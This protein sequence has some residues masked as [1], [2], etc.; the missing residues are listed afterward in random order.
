[1]KL[2]AQA[3]AELQANTPSVSVIERVPL[4]QA[5]GRIAACDVMSELAIPPADNSAMDGFA[6]HASA[7]SENVILSISQRIPAG[8]A[9]MPLEAGTAARIFTGANIPSNADTVVIQENCKF[10]GSEVGGAV[11]IRNVPERG[12]NIRPRGQDIQ[13]GATV[14]SKGQ[15]LNAVDLSLLASVGVVEVAVYE[16]LRV[17]IFST[18]DELAEPGQA[19]KEGQIYNSNRP[20]L[21]ALCTE[22][23]Y[24]VIDCGVVVD[25]LESTKVALSGAASNAHLILSSGGVSVGEE[26]HVRPAVEALGTLDMWKVQIKPGK[27]VAYGKV[28]DAAFLGLPGNPVSSFVVFQLL[29]LPLM[30]ALQGDNSAMPTTFKVRS[31]FNKKATTREEYI[32]VKLMQSDNGDWLADRFPNS[33]SGVMSSLSWADGLVRHKINSTIKVGSDVEFLPLRRALL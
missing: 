7:L 22:L 4:L 9:P 29:G 23:G 19:L 15:R 20:L 28:A 32:R 10:E 26:D 5:L 6:V 2:L 13:V 17:A 18:G 24:E 11:Q 14:I 3:Q 16:R 25:T 8:V 1:M 33:S 31:G 12:A 27:P 30:R 21:A